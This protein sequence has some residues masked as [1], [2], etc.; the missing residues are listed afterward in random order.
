MG[1]PLADGTVEVG[2]SVV[3]EERGRGYAT[4]VVQALTAR[5]L[6]APDV[7][8]VVAEVHEENAASLKVMERCG[9]YRLGTG[10]EPGHHRY[11]HRAPRPLGG[12]VCGKVSGDRSET[13]IERSL[14]ERS[15]G[16]FGQHPT[17]NPEAPRSLWQSGEL[18]MHE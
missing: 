7:Q 4:E 13:G 18:T 16:V 8:R 10:R 12:E 2:Y 11:Q 17:G 9:F 15:L 3:P 1:P 5:A 6:A 14:I